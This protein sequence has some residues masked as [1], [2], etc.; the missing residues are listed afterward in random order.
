MSRL[1]VT[2]Q[3]KSNVIQVSFKSPQ[4]VT[5][6]SVPN[7]LIALY[8][9]QR[10]AEKDRALVQ[11]REELETVILPAFRDKMQTS[12]QTLTEYRQKSGLIS[13]RNATVLGQELSETRA[14]LVIAQT[15]SAE[16]AL[17]LREV[18]RTSA[19]PGATS[20]PLTV[21]R[22]REQEVA[23][24]GQLA[25][26]KGSHGP[27]HPQTAQLEAQLKELKGGIRRESSDAIGRLK[28]GLSAALQTEA[29]LSKRV[30]ELTRQFAQV[31]GGDT[32]LQNLLFQADS[33]RKAYER[34]LERSNEL[35]SSIG[36]AQPD[37]I[38]L[39][40]ADVPLRPSLDIRKLVLAGIAIGAAAGIV[41]V[42]LLDGLLKGLRNEKQL[43][44]TL[45][46]KCLGSV[47]ILKRSPRNRRR[48]PLLQPQNT[49]FG[50]AIR[51][52]ELKLLGFDRRHA[53]QVVL[54]TAALPDEGKTWVSAS[55]AAGLA[56]DGVSVV[57]VDCDLHRPTLHRMF[58]SPRAPGLTDYFAGGAASDEIVH[59]HRLS[60]VNYVPAGTALSEEAWRITPGRL[61]PLIDR[62]AEKYAYIIL[63]SAPV[64][65]VSETML[66]SQI[67]QKTI[68]VVKW[69]STP[70]A[71]AR[72]AATQL[73]ESGATEIGTLLT[74]VDARR[75]AKHGD[76]IAGA[77]KTL[78]SYYGR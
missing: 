65:A 17:R 10:A 35:R 27:N 38:L 67:A 23:L 25:A 62:F 2:V 37:A 76:P 43:E 57:I 30:A 68:L 40:P 13:D 51:S 47:P 18:E 59:N 55:L 52:V 26:M 4:P 3:Q 36:H 41:L 42:T 70:P 5:A 78:E 6:A 24:Q 61:R 20:E 71:I 74:M 12:E 53:S 34:Y 8:L 77:Y 69:G 1:L 54:V 63:D 9:E 28:T 46:I 33:D 50:Q 32:Q 56:A 72:R 22:L 31:N 60:G 49:A 15:R 58:D 45:G 16:A 11:E 7:T 19:S 39:S 48:D 64:L 29:A 75:A 73:L 44:D 21:Q 66:L 14:Q